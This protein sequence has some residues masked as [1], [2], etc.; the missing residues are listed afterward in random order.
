MNKI[1]AI[2]ILSSLISASNSLAQDIETREVKLLAK[3]EI[4]TSPGL[5]DLLQPIN[6]GEIINNKINIHTYKTKTL[7]N[8]ISDNFV[9]QEYK[10]LGLNRYSKDISVL[11]EEE[12]KLLKRDDLVYKSPPITLE[13]ISLFKF[14]I[15]NK[16]KSVILPAFV[17]LN[18]KF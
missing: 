3:A 12:L 2:A 9:P 17:Y 14:S 4:D 6:Q 1:I 15:S 11:I 8:R 10:D 5:I 16:T 18:H 13:D 7:N